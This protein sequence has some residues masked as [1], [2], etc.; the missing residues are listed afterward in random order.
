MFESSTAGLAANAQG[1]PSTCH[2]FARHS[3]NW[4]NIIVT[5]RR[6][7]QQ[8]LYAAV[9]PNKVTGLAR[10]ANDVRQFFVFIQLLTRCCAGRGGQK[11]VQKLPAQLTYGSGLAK[12]QRR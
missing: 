7:L 12:R 6:V 2:Y 10:I 5:L 1:K 8:R 4:N 3:R 11:P 9:L